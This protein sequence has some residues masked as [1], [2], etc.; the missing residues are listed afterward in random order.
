M[1]DTD[2]NILTK[3]TDVLNTSHR[4]II[5][6]EKDAEFQGVKFQK[7]T[8]FVAD[9]LTSARKSHLKDIFETKKLVLTKNKPKSKFVLKLSEIKKITC[10]KPEQTLNPEICDKYCLTFAQYVHLSSKFDNLCE[11]N[12]N[13]IN[14][15]VVINGIDGILNHLSKFIC[16]RILCAAG[17]INNKINK[18]QYFWLYALVHFNTMPLKECARLWAKIF[19][20][21][22]VDI[23]PN[24]DLYTILF[25]LSKCCQV[26]EFSFAHKRYALKMQKLL[27]ETNCLNENGDLIIAEFTKQILEENRLILCLNSSIAKVRL[28]EPMIF[29]WEKL[30]KGVAKKFEFNKKLEQ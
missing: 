7:E 16:E 18:D 24:A 12:T 15:D 1:C 27:K 28:D 3:F 5:I 9:L 23:I 4:I 14:V 6:K 22:G 29:M 20:P 8:G 26:G 10:K 21:I 30:E 13:E 19:D 2:G 17:I 25:N 11:K